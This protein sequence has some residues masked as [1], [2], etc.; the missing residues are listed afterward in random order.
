[1]SGRTEQSTYRSRRQRTSAIAALIVFLLGTVIAWSVGGGMA[2]LLSDE[3][4]S[5][6]Y[7]RL[8]LGSVKDA[9]NGGDLAV[10]SIVGGGP[11]I[12][13]IISSSLI[14][15]VWV[16]LL[17][18]PI[19]RSG[20]KDSRTAVL[21]NEQQ[22]GTQLSLRKV[23]AN[24]KY[25]RP[26]LPRRR[27]VSG[28]EFGYCLGQLSGTRQQ[29]WV[30]FE[31]RV[32]VIARTGWGKTSRLLVPIAR[33]LP[34]AALIGSV[35]GDLFE[36]TVLARRERG[37]VRVIDFSDPSARIAEGYDEVQ[38]DPIPGCEDL[39]VA[40]RRAAALVA[41]SEDGDRQD[42]NDAFWRESARQVIEAWFHAAALAGGSIEDVLAWQ[43]D[44]RSPV[45]MDV[46]RRHPAAEQRALIALTKHL[47]ERSE[48]TTSSVER[49]IVLALGPF[50][51]AAGRRFVGVRHQS[52]DI[53]QTIA[54][55]ETIYLLAGEDTAGAASPILTLFAE[56]WFF[57]ARVLAASA[58]ARRLSPPAVAVLDELR[59]LVP[60]PSLP[61]IA[62]RD[63][64]AGIGLVYAIQ[65]MQQEVELYGPS[66]ATLEGGAV[67]VSIIGGYDTE[68]ARTITSQAGQA[69][70]STVSVGGSMFA[71]PHITDS[72]QF[73]DA[74]TIADQQQLPDGES[75]LRVAG[76]PLG[77]MFSPSFRANRRL[78]RKVA[79]EER[80]VQQSVASARVLAGGQ[81]QRE[82][83]RHNA[84]YHDRASSFEHGTD[85]AGG[86]SW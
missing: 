33:D 81:R 1:M 54:E 18:R 8:D 52:L 16:W 29:V 60:L 25:T 36:Q 40:R 11:I 13:W 57:E 72:E 14:L 19:V 7:P 49:F 45:P 59:W 9:M 46:L 12:A 10:V 85:P 21:L 56:E 65:A 37:R 77:K 78:A 50:A 61:A 27:G 35:K 5:L 68:A 86:S 41:G 30:D 26:D 67:Q 70:V 47:D 80:E 2:G 31:H 22:A 69:R 28:T 66:A 76:L 4:F 55:H 23:R 20:R 6:A 32:R 75:I 64:S 74:I 73:R 38:W 42:A 44:I 58:A 3:G 15:V 79:A 24:G 84:A 39:T 43:Q 82:F 17:V 34:G 63:R 48:R 51:S 53:R 71:G 83:D 62:S